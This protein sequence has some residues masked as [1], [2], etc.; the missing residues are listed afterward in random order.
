MKP[1]DAARFFEAIAR[2]YDRAYALDAAATRARM[3]RV[4]ARLPKAPARVLDLGVGTGRELP[5]LLDAGYEVTGLDVS[6]AML[7]ICARRGRAIALVESDLWA[8]LPFEDARFDAAIALHG[9]LAHPPTASL[10]HHAALARELARVVR[11]GG[12][13]VAEIPSRAWVDR[14]DSFDR[15]DARTTRIGE[16]RLVHEDRGARVAVEAY[17]PT[18]AEWVAAFSPWWD[19]TSDAIGEAETLLVARH[20]PATP[21]PPR[22]ASG[23][24][25]R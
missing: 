7:A 24:L 4:I 13:F 11:P 19:V 23:S 5:A 15:G 2:R 21:C 18:E 8:R 3:A 10:E 12:A 20:G 22:G 1:L 6:P 9:T 25:G 14:F 17:V 16:G